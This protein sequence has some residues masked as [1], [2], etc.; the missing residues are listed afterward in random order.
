MA[1]YGDGKLLD[2]AARVAMAWIL[3]RWIV[4]S[5]INGLSAIKHNHG[6]CKVGQS[7]IELAWC[8]TASRPSGSHK[9]VYVWRLDSCSERALHALATDTTA[10]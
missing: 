1:S 8:P 7:P 9:C 10:H 3:L 2:F 6:L 5:G 4:V